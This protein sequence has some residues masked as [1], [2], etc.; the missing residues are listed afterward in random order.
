M[1]K[2]DDDKIKVCLG[3]CIVSLDLVL[4]GVDREGLTE[5]E[6]R[7]IQEDYLWEKFLQQAMES[8]MIPPNSIRY[9]E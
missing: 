9:V 4:S 3:Y 7:M 5:R 2:D 8:E 1:F 6:M